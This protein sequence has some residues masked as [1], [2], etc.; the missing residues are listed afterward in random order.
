MKR[1]R[2]FN[3]FAFSPILLGAAA[4]FAATVHVCAQTPLDKVPEG[5]PISGWAIE[6]IPSKGGEALDSYFRERGVGRASTPIARVSFEDLAARTNAGPQTVHNGQAYFKA[7]NE[8]NYTFGIQFF[9]RG[10]PSYVASAGARNCGAAVMIGGQTIG[11]GAPTMRVSQGQ[12]GDV[13][14]T[15]NSGMRGEGSISFNVRLSAGI[16]K[17]SYLATCKRY[18][19]ISAS[20]ELQVRGPDDNEFRPFDD[21]E[22]FYMQR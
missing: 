13:A 11:R 2:M 12:N 9:Q 15:Y 21:G 16:Y 10:I 20:Y 6:V 3:S 7:V 8:G 4:V 5:R 19:Q 18:D 22:I 14:G 17:I 1:L